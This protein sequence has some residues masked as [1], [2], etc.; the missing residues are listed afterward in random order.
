LCDHGPHAGRAIEQRAVADRG[1][2]AN[3]SYIYPFISEEI[4]CHIVIQLRV[5]HSC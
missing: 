5:R 2:R 4:E 3:P 1:E